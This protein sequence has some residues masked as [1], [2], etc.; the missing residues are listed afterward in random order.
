MK[1]KF[2]VISTYIIIIFAI[3][4]ITSI[5]IYYYQRSSEI[6]LG[7]PNTL[8]NDECDIVPVLNPLGKI[9]QKDEKNNYPCED[10][11]NCEWSLLGGQ[12]VSY[13]ACCPKDWSNRSTDN[14][15]SLFR[16]LMKID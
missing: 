16:C 8:M 2:K 3:F 10:N 11:P 6:E 7:Y 12:M 15:P 9:V 5:V 13:Y 4:I 1:N 14:N